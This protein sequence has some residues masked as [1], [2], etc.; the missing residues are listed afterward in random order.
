MEGNW[1]LIRHTGVIQASLQI[2]LVR[3]GFISLPLD[4]SEEEQS[5][6]HASS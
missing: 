4:L 1:A 3:V 5:S 6:A 2:V